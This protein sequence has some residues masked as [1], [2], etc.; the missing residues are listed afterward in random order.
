MMLSERVGFPDD[1]RTLTLDRAK[2]GF[3]VVQI[4]VGFQ[5][6][7]VPFDGRDEN[8]GG[9]PWEPGYERINPCYFAVAE[10]RLGYLVRNGIVPCILGSWGYHVGFMG[11]ERMKE[12]W[13][14]LVA[15]FG[16]FPVVW[17][18]AGEA[19]MP[20]YLSKD[21][22]GDEASQLEEWSEI[23]AYV[24]E[25]DPYHHPIAMHPRGGTGSW[26]NVKNDRLIDFHMLQSGHLPDAPSLGLTL[27]EQGRTRE[28]TVPVVNAEPP[29]EAHLQAN[30]ADVQRFTFWSATLSGQAGHTYG[31]AGIFQA[32]DRERPTGPRPDGGAF[33]AMTWDD[34]MHLPGATQLGLAKALLER[35]EWWRFEPHP[36]WA[37]F[38]LR[39]GSEHY[40]P[41]V[42]AYA[43]GIPSEVRVI[44]LPRRFYHWE[45]PLVKMLERGVSYR[46][47][48]FDPTSGNEH[49]LGAVT[50]DADGHWQAPVLPVCQDWVLVLD[51]TSARGPSP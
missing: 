28:R 45:G 29:Y 7:T 30:F 37:D 15:R 35:F 22:A 2:K 48:Y 44:Y 20:Y 43:A 39:W 42:R 8:A 12:H 24:R 31:A 11:K 41:P 19:T 25:I 40:R 26:D 27:L 4:V 13:R 51:A 33:D 23:A 32:N 49:D 46:A 36:E 6:D 38:G 47:F 34:A 10:E 9:P 17:C 5:P 16:G 14:Y 18:I 21:R 50:A 3:N 1:F